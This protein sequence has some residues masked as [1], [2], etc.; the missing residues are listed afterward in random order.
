LGY[1]FRWEVIEEFRSL[2][3]GADVAL[4]ER[5]IQRMEQES[6]GRNLTKPED[7]VFDDL[8]QLPLVRAFG[9]ADQ[10]AVIEIYK[11]WELY[12]NQKGD[13]RLE[14]AFRKRDANEVA[15]CLE[16]LDKMNR[17][18]MRIGARQYAKIVDS[19]WADL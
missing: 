13:G 1:R 14:M 2:D 15:A 7:M 17:R 4:V 5:V 8:R 10:E 18:F 3:N 16:D 19:H 9:A 11:E 6:R 12:R